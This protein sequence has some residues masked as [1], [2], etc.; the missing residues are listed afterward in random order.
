MKEVS[1]CGAYRDLGVSWLVYAP[2]PSV[3]APEPSE[4]PTFVTTLWL[5]DGI[6]VLGICKAPDASL[7][8]LCDTK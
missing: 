8:S 4:V 1:I 7:S 2:E 3:Y 6:L 5:N